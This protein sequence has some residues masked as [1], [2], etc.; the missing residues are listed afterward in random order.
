VEGDG[1]KS[2][3]VQPWQPPALSIRSNVCD[4][5]AAIVELRRRAKMRDRHSREEKK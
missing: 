5:S 4:S 3:T 2:F 1:G